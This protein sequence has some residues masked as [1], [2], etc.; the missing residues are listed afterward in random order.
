[1]KIINNILI[2]IGTEEL[3]YKNLYKTSK[4][5]KEILLNQLKKYNFKIKNIK[6]F[7]TIRRIAFIIEDI[8]T[9]NN[10][11]LI[12]ELIKI[13]EKS[14][15]EI[16]FKIKMRWHSNNKPFIR[17][18]KWY[19]LLLNKTLINHSIFNIDSQKNTFGH[20]SIKTQLEIT[21]D[22]Y[23]LTLKKQGYV[24][25]DYIKRKNL[26]LNII[27]TYAKKH[28]SNIILK[29]DSLSN[30]TSLIEYPSL[31]ISTFKKNFLKIPEEI[32]TLALLKDQFCFLIKK[33]NKLTNKVV[34]IADSIKKN[35]NIR[36]GYNYILNTKLSEIQYLYDNEK[37]YLQQKNISDLKNLVLNEKLGNMYDKTIR[38]KNIV[39]FLKNFL[40]IKSK[41]L[42]IATSFLK[43]D[44]LTK[45][46]TEIPDLIGLI[47][48]YNKKNIKTYL[49]NY[50]RIINN[51]I[52]KNINS[53]IIAL[54]DKIDNITSFFIIDKKPTGSKDPFNL[55]KDAR[56]IIKLININKININLVNLIDYSL[57]Q[58]K[59]KEKKLQKEILNFILQRLKYKKELIQ[60]VKTKENIL[61]LSTIIEVFNNFSKYNFSNLLL[62]SIKR[63]SKITDKNKISLKKKINKKLLLTSQEI[64]LLKEL[65]EKLKI[66]MILNKNN[67]FFESTKTSVL[68]EKTIN[69]FFT[70]VLI[71]DKNI[72]LKENRLKILNI[73]K[74]LFSI[75]INFNLIQ[76]N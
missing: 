54:A 27:K 49:Y 22:T 48:G 35:K 60:L 45:L 17:P 55:R 51:K 40:N 41:N 59:I 20:K 26:I 4:S 70:S 5:I 63:I 13:I 1:M 75:K 7:I 76:S 67:L 21:P 33:N 31:I 72:E 9:L 46:I 34:I 16:K 6:N 44:L 23:E 14:L 2:E 25:C 15:D 42:I 62:K 50:N 30:I 53:A 29:K 37:N 24:I 69:N 12:Q 19:T 38:I 39:I 61:M 18:I 64:I 11:N 28:A 57:N 73:I 3:P 10:T 66:I 71:L 32:I 58:H 52:K 65:R 36:L 56:T 43:M 74:R 47:C 8:N 68:L